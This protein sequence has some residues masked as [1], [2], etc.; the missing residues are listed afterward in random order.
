MA[1]DYFELKNR[2]KYSHNI[3]LKNL[4]TVTISIIIVVYLNSCEIIIKAP[5][6]YNTGTR[7]GMVVD[8]ITGL[9]VAG[10]VVVY[11]WDIGTFDF[12]Q[13]S[14]HNLIVY[15]SIT[16]ANGRYSVPNQKKTIEYGI[17]A[18]ELGPENV[19][20]YRF[21]YVWYS[22]HN[23]KPDTFMEYMPDLKQKYQKENN[24]I[25]LQ[26]WNENLSHREH[27]KR[28]NQSIGINLPR[29]K[30][31]AALTEERAIAK[32]E[33]PDD[34]GFDRQS[35]NIYSK[36]NED[37]KRFERG[38]IGKAQYIQLLYARLESK[39]VEEI[40]ST[41]IELSKFG[42]NNGVGVIVKSLKDRLYRQDFGRLLGCIMKITGREDLRYVLDKDV[43]SERI[44]IMQDLE[45]WWQNN[46][47]RRQTESKAEL[48]ISDI[49]D[50]KKEEILNQLQNN[51]D[52]SATEY[53]L[54]FIKMKGQ[55]PELFE[56]AIDLLAKSNHLYAKDGI[57]SMLYN[58]DVYIRRKAALTL[59]LAGEKRGI[60][61]M[62]A[63]L[64]SK[65]SNSR[66]VANAALREMTGQDFSDGKSLRNMPAE[67]EK[68]VIAKW[69]DWWNLN[70]KTLKSGRP[71]EFERKII[72]DD[73]AMQKRYKAMD[74]KESTNP[75]LPEFENPVKTPKAT[76]EQFKAALLKDDVKT[77][78]S[79]MSY[80]VK[81]QYEEIFEQMGTNRGD[82][83]K[84]LGKIYFSS[85]LGNMLYYE[86]V[87]ELDDGL[88]AFPVNFAQDDDGN[89]LIIE[90]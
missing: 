54:R 20:A 39:N 19:I 34:N 9:P 67:K 17:L 18:S 28:F 35:Y 61:M 55:N 51:Y 24:I 3:V 48:L 32:K 58:P 50:K 31:E 27:I 2:R 36:M 16:D 77:A 78:L 60:P 59:N 64:S 49:S 45:S 75:E 73:S 86:M 89:W 4:L 10:A 21:G 66:S 42:D 71:E 83:A 13:S 79:L 72:N 88:I 23:G 82:Y 47:D 70:C 56:K 8:A 84:G 57:G 29:P 63:K 1:R 44:K 62:I 87:T 40:A 69:M 52:E 33:K 5:R 80:P 90:F 7:S 15:E 68:E 46:K 37:R 26:P 14:T 12:I 25:K 41:A 85:K 11:S 30:L 81:E 74:E 65:S 53:I 38:E 76:F 6:T 22:V 43:I